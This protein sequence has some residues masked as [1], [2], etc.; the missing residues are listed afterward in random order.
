MQ[1]FGQYRPIHGRPVVV[2]EEASPGHAGR[3]LLLHLVVRCQRVR[4]PYHRPRV[5]VRLEQSRNQGRAPLLNGLRVLLRLQHALEVTS[6]APPL[7]VA[8]VLAAPLEEAVRAEHPVHVFGQFRRHPPLAPFDLAEMARTVEAAVDQLLERQPGLLPFPAQLRAVEG[9]NACRAVD[10]LAL[11]HRSPS[12]WPLLS[13]SRR[14]RPSPGGSPGDAN[15]ICHT[16]SSGPGAR[17]SVTVRGAHQ[18]ASSSSQSALEG[19]NPR[20]TTIPMYRT[21]PRA[22]RAT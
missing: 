5:R 1:R 8:Y 3:D 15:R 11:S 7:G 20:C 6:V 17:T 16:R 14:V 19:V 13:V 10:V 18:T 22:L 4:R 9:G 12:W 2:L 21:A